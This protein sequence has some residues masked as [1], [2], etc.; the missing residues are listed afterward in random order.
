MYWY[1]DAYIQLTVH[2]VH[3]TVTINAKAIC[4]DWYPDPN[5]KAWTTQ[6]ALK[7]DS[8]QGQTAAV[9]IDLQADLVLPMGYQF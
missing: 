7:Q 2:H 3:K 1:S 8:P 6:A 5:T 9:A 4:V